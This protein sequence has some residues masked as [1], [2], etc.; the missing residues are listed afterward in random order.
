M[1]DF[2]IAWYFRRKRK[3]CM[4]LRV[5]RRELRD[6]NNPFALPED[7]FVELF[8]FKQD[9]VVHLVDIL[10]PYLVGPKRITAISN[11]I[12][13]LAALNFYGGGSYQ[14]IVGEDYHLGT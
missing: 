6:L 9:W 5:P 4:S 14:R 11:H 1:M 12:K 8:R 3:R 2:L 7:R 10:T 13:V